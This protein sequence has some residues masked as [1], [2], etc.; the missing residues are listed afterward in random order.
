VF[1]IVP[2]GRAIKHDVAF[3][4]SELCEA[5]QGAKGKPNPQPIYRVGPLGYHMQM[6]TCSYSTT[7]LHKLLGRPL[8]PRFK[9]PAL[10][11]FA[12]LALGLTRCREATWTLDTFDEQD[13]H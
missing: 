12:L 3:V 5:G 1:E 6:V 4:I 9:M 13:H 8:V 11:C 7:V 2:V 10:A